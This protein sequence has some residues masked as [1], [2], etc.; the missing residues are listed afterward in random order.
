MPEK[1]R[2]GLVGFGRMGQE[3]A[4]QIANSADMLVEV[5]VEPGEGNLARARGFYEKSEVSVFADL[6]DGIQVGDI[7]G[8]IVSSSTKSHVAIGRTLLEQGQRV[9]LEKP[10]ADSLE[11]A[12]G[13]RDLVQPDSANLMMGHIVLW[14]PEFQDLRSKVETHG[15]IQVINALRQRSQSHRIDYPGESLFS[16]LMVHDLYC[17]QSLTRCREPIEIV[18]QTRTHSLGGD[19]WAKA[20]LTWADGTEAIAESNYF[21]PD[22]PA[23]LIDDEISVRGENWSE[24]VGFQGDFDQALRNELAHFAALLRGEVEVIVGARYEDALQIQGWVD[25]LISSAAANSKGE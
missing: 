11:S 14:S 22:M 3:H 17:I 1:L 5:I 23:G 7:D 18:G 2:I 12:L 9:L 15:E 24:S 25:F 16:L 6:M 4:R 20:H 19:D 21:L 8:W 10:I 13:L